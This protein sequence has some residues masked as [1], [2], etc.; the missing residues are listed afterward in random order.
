[1]NYQRGDQK[2]R[3]DRN[4]IERFQENAEGIDILLVITKRNVR[5][6]SSKSRDGHLPRRY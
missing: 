2:F 4:G 3:Y 5:R 6:V 1:M